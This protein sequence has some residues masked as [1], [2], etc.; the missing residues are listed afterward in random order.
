MLA[1]ISYP[2]IP[3]WEVG[4]FRFSLHGV[5]AAVGFAAGAWIATRE[6]RRR[7]F[8]TVK[9][10]S[11]L[12]WGL[13]GALLGA[14]YSTVPAALLDGVPLGQ[15]LNPVSGNF[16]IMGGF[17]GGI[18]AGGWRMRRVGLPI[19]AT[20]DMSAFGLAL[21]TVVGRIGDL[22][23]VEHLGRETE[24]PW[25]YG[26][27]PGYDVAPAH[28]ALECTEAAAGLDGFCGVYHHAA[29]YDMVG[30]ALLLGVLYLVYRRFKLHYGQLFF[31]WVAWYG[32][33]RFLIDAFRFGNQAD[34]TIGPL[35]W[36]QLSGFVAGLAGLAAIVWLEGKTPEVGPDEDARLTGP[37]Q[38]EGAAAAD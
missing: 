16:S 27:R 14:R 4:P 33:Q 31:L 22:A 36:N 5:F 34:A 9:Y 30:A 28:D 8:D 37:R 11:V 17:A 12:T 6:M 7:G 3:I 24:T 2:P 35:T 13:V 25:G 38:A 20:L 32:W 18:L 15:A 29:M 1:V 26:I 10:Q 21:G 23:I 19:L